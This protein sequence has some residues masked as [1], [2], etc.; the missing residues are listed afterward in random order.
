MNGVGFRAVSA[1]RKSSLRRSEGWCELGVVKYRLQYRRYALPFRSPVRTGHGVWAEREGLIVRLEDEAGVAGY[2][3]AAPIPHFKTETVDA[4]EAGVRLLGE[5]TST[6]EL[7]ELPAGLATLRQAVGAA[8]ERGAAAVG[9]RDFLGVAALLSAGRAAFAQV[10]SRVEMGFRVFKWK[11]GVG[12][13]AD[14]LAMLED[15]CA[16]LPTGGKLR[17]DANGAWDRR[18]AERCLERCAGCPVE[19]LEQPIAADAR[20][21]ADVLLGLA[22]D[23]PTPVALDESLVGEEDIERWIGAG[24]PGVYVVKPA[25]LGDARGAMAWLAQ[26]KADV[27]FSSALE[28]AVGAQTALRLALAWPG[29]P[30][31]VGFG[32]WPRF[33]DDRF[34]GPFAAPFFRAEDVARLNPEDVWSALS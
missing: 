4:A 29:E 24:W 32:V 20:G 18:R 19:F 25:L 28:T 34:D 3:E 33:V 1:N 30:R 15:L 12:D 31:A 5:W 23:Y 26:A 10:G 2:G 16:E 21:A 17:L 27:V 22:G 14:E 13:I 7:G 8:Q 6:E 11:V 9:G